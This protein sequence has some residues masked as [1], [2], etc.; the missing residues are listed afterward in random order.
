MK[1]ARRRCRSNCDEGALCV[2]RIPMCS[3]LAPFPGSYAP[4][5]LPSANN[6]S[7][8]QARCLMWGRCGGVGTESLAVTAIKYRSNSKAACIVSP[9]ERLRI[10]RARAYPRSLVHLGAN[11]MSWITNSDVVSSA[12]TLF[13]APFP[14]LAPATGEAAQCRAAR[15]P[16]G[17]DG[18]G[19]RSVGLRRCGRVMLSL[20][21]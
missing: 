10:Q 6:C 12:T 8:E 13:S 18:S 20:F 14:P 9:K 21:R 3:V 4:P 17:I 19:V 2:D 16:K 5:P 1:G 15:G 7:C 11:E